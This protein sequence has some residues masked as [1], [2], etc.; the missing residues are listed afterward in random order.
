MGIY[1]IIWVWLPVRQHMVVEWK[2]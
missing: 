2:I 1:N